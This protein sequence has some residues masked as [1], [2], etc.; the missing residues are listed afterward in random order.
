MTEQPRIPITVQNLQEVKSDNHRQIYS[1]F[2]RVGL[3]PWDIAIIFGIINDAAPGQ[4]P[5]TTSEVTIRMSPHQFKAFATSLPLILA[6][7]EARFGEINLP[8]ALKMSAETMH[9]V[10]RA[11]EN[12]AL[13][14][15]PAGKSIDERQTPKKRL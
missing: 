1:N 2:S 5:S 10:L 4:P 12:A 3:S 9:D 11:A 13:V 15:R 8:Q 14:P 7:W 6:E